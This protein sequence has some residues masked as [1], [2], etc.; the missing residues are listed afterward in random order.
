MLPFTYFTSNTY[1]QWVCSIVL[2][3]YVFSSV[4]SP[5][6]FYFMLNHFAC[7]LLLLSFIL[8]PPCTTLYMA[9]AGGSLD[10]CLCVVLTWPSSGSTVGRVVGACMCVVPHNRPPTQ[11]AILLGSFVYS[12]ACSRISTRSYDLV[13]NL[14]IVDTDVLMWCTSSSTVRTRKHPLIHQLTLLHI[15]SLPPPPRR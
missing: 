11:S 9:L 3:F 10:G 15:C 1:L 4:Q 6:E 7:C 12:S 14:S 5:D 13:Y 8:V 2:F